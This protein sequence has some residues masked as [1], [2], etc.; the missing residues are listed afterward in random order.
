MSTKIQIDGF[1]V[2]LIIGAVLV[3]VEIFWYVWTRE[4]RRWYRRWKG[5]H[6][7]EWWLDSPE[8]QFRWFQHRYCETDDR[9]EL[10]RGTPTCEEWPSM[11]HPWLAP[12]NIGRIYQY[13]SYVLR[14]KWYVFWAGWRLTTTWKELAL[15]AL[16]DANK[17]H[18]AMF[19]P[20]AE[21]F[22]H[23]DGSKTTTMGPD[24]FQIYPEATIRF[25]RAWLWH[26]KRSKHHPQY[27]ARVVSVPCLHPDDVL[28]NDSG[29]A[30]CLRCDRRYPPEQIR[31]VVEEQLLYHGLRHLTVSLKAMPVRYVTEML[32]DWIGAGLAQGSPDTLRWYQTRGYRLPLHPITRAIVEMRLGVPQYC[33]SEETHA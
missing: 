10:G 4:D 8:H 30:R 25:N 27:W 28:L 21:Y 1:T 14:H 7:E 12:F 33:T 15:C 6:W 31:Q 32:C 16:H 22:Y 18:P 2:G 5:G 24:G 11:Q 3:V 17:F 26:I 20:Y 19:R 23:P 9:P 13:M 29:G